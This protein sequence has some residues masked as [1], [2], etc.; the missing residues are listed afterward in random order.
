M[1]G[2]DP[3]IHVDPRVKPGGDGNCCDS[4]STNNALDATHPMRHVLTILSFVA[5]EL[6]LLLCGWE[7]RGMAAE[8]MNYAAIVAQ[9]DAKRFDAATIWYLDPKVQTRTAVTPQSLVG[10]GCQ[11]VLKS[12]S[13]KW[14]RLVSMLKAERPQNT[15]AEPSDIRWGILF[16]R[17]ADAS[18]QIF[19][20]PIYEP[21]SD[22]TKIFGYVDSQK[23]YFRAKLPKDMTAFIQGMKCITD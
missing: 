8:P 14:T 19:F 12:D 6:A 10:L 13:P 20:G 18:G 9:A 4:I 1:A 23:V 22:E 2:L 5:A 17:P 11:I 3:A 16:R 7:P 21:E 15:D